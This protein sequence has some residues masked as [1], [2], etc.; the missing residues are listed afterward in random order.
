MPDLVLLAKWRGGDVAAGR[1]LCGRHID[2]VARFFRNKLPTLPCVADHVNNTFLELL[3]SEQ[4]RSQRIGHTASESQPAEADAIVSFRAWLLGIACNVFLRYLRKEYR[5]REIDLQHESLETLGP[6]SMSSIFSRARQVN[7]LVRA[8]RALPIEDQMLLEAKF[9]EYFSDPELAHMLK[10]PATTLPRRIVRAKQRL[11]TLVERE[12]HCEASS[13]V[14]SLDQWITELRK[15]LVRADVPEERTA[16]R[17]GTSNEGD[18][19][20]AS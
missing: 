8:L 18:E 6:G 12:R 2:A 1:E 15:E 19:E 4:R 3:E 10:I 20:G 5:R 14:E 16:A 17:S 9:F 13:A 7:V 11:V